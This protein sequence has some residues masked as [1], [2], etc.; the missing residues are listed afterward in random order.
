MVILYN[1]SGYILKLFLKFAKERTELF[2]S[3]HASSA[4]NTP[5][6]GFLPENL[7]RLRHFRLFPQKYLAGQL[8]IS[9][10]AYSKMERGLAR[11]SKIQMHIIAALYGLEASDLRDKPPEALIR[12]ILS[13]P[14]D[15]N[16]PPFEAV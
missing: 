3:N 10:A 15:G 13:S 8:G 16:R 11:V 12:Q 4:M 2:Q 5:Y 14:G 6:S 9:L 1:Q 7:R